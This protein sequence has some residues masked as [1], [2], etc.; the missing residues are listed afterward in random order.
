MK[1]NLLNFLLVIISIVSA[2][3][4]LEVLTR[5]IYRDT[6]T[7]LYEYR[8]SLP[9][10]YQDSTY[11]SE[12]FLEESF[13]QPGGWTV[14]PNTRLIIP[15]DFHGKYFNI[16]K[17]IR[18][19]TDN[20]QKYENTVFVFGGST[21]YCSEVPDYYTIPS[22]L[23]RLINNKFPNRYRVL[24]YGTTSVNTYQQVE[25]LKTVNIG[26]NDIVIFY[27]GINDTVLLTTG[28]PEGWILGEN[29]IEYTKLNWIQRLNFW[30]YN[31][32][33][34]ESKFVAIFLYPYTKVIPQHLTDK[35][36]LSDL[37][38]RLKRSYTY[39]IKS[40]DSLCREKNAF[41]YNFLQPSV[42]TREPNTAYEIQLINNEFLTP[43]AW[44][45]AYAGSYS[46]LKNCEN[47]FR[48]LG[49]KSHDLSGIFNNQKDDYYLDFAHITEKGNEIIAREIFKRVFSNVQ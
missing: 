36:Q 16:S 44:K 9:K 22:I 40:A 29:H 49:I 18:H 5:I 31:K 41:F 17:G 8:K 4:V 1:K 10:P 38:Q 11:F 25:R 19:T 2:Y 14:P 48:S 3:A 43:A 39:N 46:V 30:I 27:N 32:Y 42:F 28:R 6:P 21:I 45:I 34:D 23:Q 24:N 7:S 20:P 37:Q 13:S 15:N 35:K 26:R 47:D 33:N 12:E